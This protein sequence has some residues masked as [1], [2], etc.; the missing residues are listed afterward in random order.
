MT[1]VKLFDTCATSRGYSQVSGVD[2][3]IESGILFFRQSKEPIDWVRN[4]LAVIPCLVKLDKWR[5][6]PLGAW[7]VYRRVRFLRRAN[8]KRTCGISQGGWPAVMLSLETGKRCTTFGCP[9]F[10]FS[11]WPIDA[12]HIT[13]KN[14]IICRLPPWCKK[15]G[16][17]YVLDKPAVK[18]DTMSQAEWDTGH[19]LAEYRQRIG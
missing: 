8:F 16:V 3:K 18:P 2:Y 4:V 19:T 11:N 6:V 5:V 7:L 13:T 15:P 1:L 12:L 14:D 9:R 10:A 17:T